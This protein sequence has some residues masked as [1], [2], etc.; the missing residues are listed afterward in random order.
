MEENVWIHIPYSFK[1]LLNS[2]I[3]Y[4]SYDTSDK[5]IGKLVAYKFNTGDKEYEKLCTFLEK[6]NI[7]FIIFRREYKF[8]NSEINKAELLEFVVDNSA[9]RSYSPD[10]KKFTICNNCGEELPLL[11]YTDLH[12]DFNTIKK[13]DI[14]A[15]Y[16]IVGEII[17]SQ[18][19]RDILVN[20]GV[21]GIDYYPIYQFDSNKQL[22][23]GF[24]Q[25]IIEEGI[26][27]VEEPAI[28][29]TK[30]KCPVCG[31]YKKF[32]CQTPL[33][34]NKN[35]WRNLDIC[36]TS[37]WFGAPPGWQGKKILISPKLYKVLKG[38][39][40]KGFSVRPAFFKN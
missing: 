3:K 31:F 30:D 15:T 10:H 37:N 25:L 17:V 13:Y 4:Y 7:Q 32:L 18:S 24:Y 12:V 9:K 19:L 2:W 27:E 39:H 8:S 38:Y 5:N 11:H 6:N 29:E 21:I 33:Y 35:T 26:G 23:E 36:F 34:F 22:I 28:V 20:E 14:S 40:I 16:S 1:D